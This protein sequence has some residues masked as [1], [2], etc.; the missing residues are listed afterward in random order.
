MYSELAWTANALCVCIA[1]LGRQTCPKAHVPCCLCPS[2]MRTVLLLVGYEVWF[3]N[4]A[5]FW[6][7]VAPGSPDSHTSAEWT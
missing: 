7:L 1:G 2:S 3:W 5:T 6:S 4:P